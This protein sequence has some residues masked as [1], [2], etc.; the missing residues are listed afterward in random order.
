MDMLLFAISLCQDKILT[1]Q[2]TILQ[3]KLITGKNFVSDFLLLQ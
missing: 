2:Q 3:F 1:F